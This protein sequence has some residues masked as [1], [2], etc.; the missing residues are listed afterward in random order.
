MSTLIKSPSSESVFSIET[1]IRQWTCY[2]EEVEKYRRVLAQGGYA[3]K[4][5][6]QWEDP[7]G[8]WAKIAAV[9]PIM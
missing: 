1:G 3:T 8:K 7:R 9:W 2:A 6:Y 4:V 5:I